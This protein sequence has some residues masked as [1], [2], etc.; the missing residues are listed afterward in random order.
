MATGEVIVA[1]IVG[2][3]SYLAVKGYQAERKKEKEGC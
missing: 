2:I 1:V 3:I